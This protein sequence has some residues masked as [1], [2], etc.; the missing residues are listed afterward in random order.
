MQVWEIPSFG[1]EN[2]RQ[3]TR[4]E[5]QPGAGEVLV[6]I[7][8]VSL[9]YRDLMMTKGQYNPKMRLP[10][11]PCSDGAGE[12]IAIGSGVT[13]FE[14]G[15]PVVGIFMQRWLGGGIVE[16]Y[17]KSALGGEIDGT[18][19]EQMIFSEEGLLPMPKHLTMEEAATLPCA[20]VTAWHALTSGGLQAGDSILLQGTG[21]VSIFGLQ[22]ARAMGAR[23]L[24]TSSSDAKLAKAKAL[25]AHAT[26]NYRLH[27]DW[28]K[29][30]RSETHGIGVDH[31]LEVG[32]AGTLEKSMKA[33]RAGGRISL[34]GVLSGM[35]TMNPLPL[36]IRNVTLEGIFVGS[37]AMFEAMNKAL[38]LHQIK[39]IVD[40]VFDF[41]QFP[42]ALQYLESGAHFGKVV[43]TL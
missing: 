17:A 24:V 18:L 16:S 10:R 7:R 3:A 40:R 36:L 30:C 39:P 41:A 6:R 42:D 4:P 9:N 23:T 43:I 38:E 27:S 19:A 35:G 11:V 15:D 1:I 31:I 28:E 32:G 22:L 37:R 25:G 5:Y 21:G 34:I 14:V 26:C 13:R 2:L 8:A 20:A 29:W 33:I 12:V